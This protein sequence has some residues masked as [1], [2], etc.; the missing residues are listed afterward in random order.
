MWVCSIASSSGCITHLLIAL[1]WPQVTDCTSTHSQRPDSLA[2]HAGLR[3]LLILFADAHLLLSEGLSSGLGLHPK[4]TLWLTCSVLPCSVPVSSPAALAHSKTERAL[5]T[6]ASATAALPKMQ[7]RATAQC[8]HLL[9]TPA[10]KPRCCDC[11]NAALNAVSET[12]VRLYLLHAL[13]PPA[14]YIAAAVP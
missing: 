7:C 9:L 8:C 13:L 1:S 4:G 6:A 10:Q 14:A 11:L 12:S 2:S 3:S 5:T